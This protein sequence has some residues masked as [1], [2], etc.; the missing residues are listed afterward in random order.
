MKHECVAKH[1]IKRKNTLCFGN[2]IKEFFNEMGIQNGIVREEKNEE[3]RNE[4]EWDGTGNR[5]GMKMEHF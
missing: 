3:N 1:R 2:K 5:N 4:T